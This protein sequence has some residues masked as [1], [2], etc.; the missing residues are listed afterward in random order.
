[1]TFENGWTLGPSKVPVGHI[2]VL[3]DNR[4]NS[5]GKRVL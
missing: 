1:M 3:G 2:F 4:D 5:A